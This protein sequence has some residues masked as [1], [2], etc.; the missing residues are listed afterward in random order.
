MKIGSCQLGIFAIFSLLRW[1]TLSAM[2]PVPVSAVVGSV[3][4]DDCEFAVVMF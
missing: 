3:S 1:L 2:C 4:L